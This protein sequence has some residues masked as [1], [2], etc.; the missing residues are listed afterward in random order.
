M[1]VNGTIPHLIAG[2]SQEQPSQRQP[3]HCDL[4]EN[5]FLSQTDGMAKRPPTQHI[6][7]VMT[8]NAPDRPFVHWINRSETER[9]AMLFQ[10][11]VAP[12]ITDLAGTLYPVI[13]QIGPDYSYLTC[14]GN[15]DQQLRA[16]TIGD[17]TFVLNT[18]V[19]STGV[20]GAAA[21]NKYATFWIKQAINSGVYKVVVNGTPVTVTAPASAPTTDGIA[22][23]IATALSTALGA[24]WSVTQVASS[25][26]VAQNP[27]GTGTFAID[28]SDSGGGN[29]ISL[30]LNQTQ[31]FTNLAPVDWNG[32]VVKVLGTQGNQ[33]VPIYYKFSTFNGTNGATGVWQE[34]YGENEKTLLNST[35]LPH[36]L[37]RL[38]DTT[39]TVTGTV[40]QYYF[41][42]NVTPWNTRTVGD[43]TNAP[44]PSFA[45]P[46]NGP[47]YINDIFLYR[48]RLGILCE[49][50]VLFSQA[51]NFYNFWRTTMLSVLDSDPIDVSVAHPRVGRLRH[52]CPAN[53]DCLITSDTTQFVIQAADTLTPSGIIITAMTEY[54]VDLYCRPIPVANFVYLP[55]RNTGYTGIREYYVEYYTQRRVGK[56]V[57]DQVPKYIN[58][59]PLKMAHCV[60]SDLLGVLADND[61]GS[62]YVY[63]W[64]WIGNQL[65]SA[66]KSQSAWSRWNFDL[67]GGG[68]ATKVHGINFIG[69]TMYLLVGRRP[70]SGLDTG[71]VALESMSMDSLPQDTAATYTTYLDQRLSHN[72]PGVSITYD[73]PSN[74]TGIALTDKFY[75]VFSIVTATDATHSGGFVIPNL[76]PSGPN[77][78]TMKGN[79]VGVPLFLGVPY[80]LRYRFSTLYMREQSPAAPGQFT[81]ITNGRLQ[82]RTLTLRF[83][84]TGYFRLEITP[85]QRDMNTV[86]YSTEILGSG[87][88]LLGVTPLRS[89]KFRTLVGA[90]NDRVQIDIVN[91]SP[92][93]CRFTSA[94]WEGLYYARARRT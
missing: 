23:S 82:I 76:G 31:A 78:Y 27:V 90:Q 21:T 63:Q 50:N 80:T 17:T 55:Y 2:V 32:H 94:E 85:N 11:G 30:Y 48:N 45:D 88:T 29:A 52:A 71:T 49:Q 51:G 87:Q 72:S 44:V 91:D 36:T 58:G 12:I 19:N 93:P 79:W 33:S 56:S 83:T 70:T 62:V 22:A 68:I 9:Y 28:A 61:R 16:L 86:P 42:W 14:P 46:T 34:W 1:L 74:T 18:S 75:G 53:R 13:S 24:G 84:N 39:G 35:N 38:I 7:N 66:E 73:A 8:A 59:N 40:G 67:P 41:S 64:K 77:S 65:Y 6:A 20:T 15:P 60:S 25:V 37:T 5:A 89:D 81:A 4:C 43:S 92:L 47:R 54:D 57:T 3:T 69:Q 10:S 26:I